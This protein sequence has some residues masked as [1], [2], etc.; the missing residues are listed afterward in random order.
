MAELKER[1]KK[2]TVEEDNKLCASLCSTERN[3]ID[4]RWLWLIAVRARA[5]NKNVHCEFVVG[6]ALRRTI[7]KWAKDEEAGQKKRKKKNEEAEKHSSD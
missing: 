1:K 4:Y 3:A 7:A 2:K 5:E 6:V